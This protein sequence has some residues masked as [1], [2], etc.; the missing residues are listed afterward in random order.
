MTL[1]GKGEGKGKRITSKSK[2][3][4]KLPASTRRLLINQAMLIHDLYRPHAIMDYV[5][6]MKGTGFLPVSHAVIKADVDEIRTDTS[7]KYTDMAQ[8][9]TT[10]KISKMLTRIYKEMLDMEKMVDALLIPDDWQP[11]ELEHQTIK[12]LRKQDPK[13]GGKIHGA[14][15]AA[16]NIHHALKSVTLKSIAGMIAFLNEQIDKKRQ[17]YIDML[18]AYP[19]AHALKSIKE[20]QGGQEV[21][22]DLQLA[23]E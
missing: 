5:N 11:G 21:Q 8:H 14:N 23:P 13:H 9:G 7:N 18:A 16:D 22:H 17:L 3:N 2:S 12:Q 6:M 19:L 1:K 15:K 10:F 20:S 4:K